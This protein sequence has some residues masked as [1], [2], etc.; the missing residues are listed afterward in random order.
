MRMAPII[1]PP[2]GCAYDKHVERDEVLA[3]LRERIVAFAASR[4]RK[5]AAEDLAQ[6]TL[7]LLQEKYRH[8]ERLEELVPLAMRI[9]RFK[10]VAAWRKSRRRGEDRAVAVEDQ[11]LPDLSHN[12]G[13]EAERRETMERLKGA[14][15]ML[16]ERCR[17]LFRLKLEG[18][19]F[20]QI[21]ERMGAATV[22]TVYT[23]DHRC[24]ERL[25]EL[26]GDA[27][28]MP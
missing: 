6:D 22:N 18:L 10:L 9:L 16:P 24:R 15:R 20:P 25:R 21:R 17:E 28:G 4:S 7:M 27:W 12:P 19:S 11:P 26:M 23:W 5:E 8:V 13:D 14:L 3:K 2:P 1:P